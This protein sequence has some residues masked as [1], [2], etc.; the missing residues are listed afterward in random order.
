MDT[1]TSR[2][3]IT[4]MY[5]QAMRLLS[6]ELAQNPRNSTASSITCLL[7]IA[8]E[9]RQRRRQNALKHGLS[10]IVPSW[11]RL[12]R[13]RPNA[14]DLEF[15]LRIF[16]LQTLLYSQGVRLAAIEPAN[17]EHL[18]HL[19]PGAVSNPDYIENRGI[20]VLHS[21][22]SFIAQVHRQ[23]ILFG[24]QPHIDLRRQRYVEHLQQIIDVPKGTESVNRQH[25]DM[26]WPSLM[27]KNLCRMTIL[28]LRQ[29]EAINELSWDLFLDSFEAIVVSAS[30]IVAAL[31]SRTLQQR[32]PF[33]IHIGLI[34]PLSLVAF[35][36]RQLPVRVR[37]IVLL[38]QLGQEGPFVGSLVAAMAERCLQVEERQVSGVAEY[39][40]SKSMH[41][42]RES[43]DLPAETYRFTKCCT[44][45]NNG[46]ADDAL[47]P[48]TISGTTTVKFVKR[49]QPCSAIQA[50][51]ITSSY[52]KAGPEFVGVSDMKLD[53]A[54]WEEYTEQISFGSK[55]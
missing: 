24:Q 1:T 53:P 29:L 19:V 6:T 49:K 46:E 17:L 13:P 51:V 8:V 38:R 35:K 33:T 31:Q 16:D 37:A 3:D 20:S 32:P 30:G 41:V 44:V 25:V 54:V 14:S 50:N 15:V 34:A 5:G 28:Q 36:C 47:W 12:T 18:V 26:Y 45:E 11:Y 21:A 55:S 42:M 43:C 9:L 22:H 2:F 4:E 7:L 27:I 48:T 40:T 10:G 39:V 23:T 52:F